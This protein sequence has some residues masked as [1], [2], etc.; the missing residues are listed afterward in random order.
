MGW[1]TWL[2]GGHSSISGGEGNNSTGTLSSI[3]GGV[4]NIASGD[5]SSAVGK[6]HIMHGACKCF[7]HS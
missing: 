4:L 1:R 5:F 7:L 3:S 2:R 6:L